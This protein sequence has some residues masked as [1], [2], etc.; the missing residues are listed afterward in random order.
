[1]QAK[2]YFNEFI[3]KYK[4]FCISY[5]GISNWI[6]VSKQ[7][8]VSIKMIRKIANENP[9][10]FKTAL[11]KRK[12]HNLSKKHNKFVNDDLVK[13]NYKTPNV[14]GVDGTNMKIF[15]EDK[16]SYKKLNCLIYYIWENQKVLAYKFDKN[17]NSNSVIKVFENI[18]TFANNNNKK[19]IIQSERGSAFANENIFNFVKGNKKITHSMS[20]KGFKHNSPT[21]S[22]NGW[23]KQK[24]IKSFGDKFKNLNHFLNTFEKFIKHW[25]FMKEIN[26]NIIS[27]KKKTKC[28]SV[29]LASLMLIESLLKML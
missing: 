22:L 1:M 11:R 2:R 15:L 25:N 26:Y 19:L 16:N 20:E 17:E 21:E 10:V 5:S 8:N 28:N 13:M 23:I 24:F 18:S 4:D 29:H 14:I 3:K 6:K 27:K 7:E 12:K 9:N